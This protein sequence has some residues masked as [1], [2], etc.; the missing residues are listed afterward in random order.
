[1]RDTPT[2]GPQ[3][4]YTGEG[5]RDRPIGHFA[6]KPAR[7]ASMLIAFRGA[8]RIPFDGTALSLP[9]EMLRRGWTWTAFRADRNASPSLAH[10]ISPVAR[11]TFALRR[12]GKTII[13]E[14]SPRAA[15]HRSN[16]AHV[17][18]SR[19]TEN[20]S[21]ARQNMGPRGT[22]IFS[23]LP[24]PHRDRREIIRAQLPAWPPARCGHGRSYHIAMT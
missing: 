14:N 20:A 16:A 17:P 23:D 11:E 8:I 24:F 2:P 10:G 9:T 4:V 15:E 22:H 13:R 1:M 3:E 19:P 7:S 21:V 18:L 12:S 6:P 5:Q